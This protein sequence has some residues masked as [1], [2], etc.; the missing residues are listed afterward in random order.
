MKKRVSWR[1][2]RIIAAAVF[3]AVAVA[4][5]T[6]LAGMGAM[7]LH[8]Q[9]GPALL[10]LIAAFSAG[11]LAA[12]LG[13][14]LVTYL[15]GRFYCAVF[16]PLGI[17]QDV[18]GFLSRRKAVETRNFAWLRYAVAGVVFGMLAFGWTAGFFLLDPYSGFGRIVAS[19]SL[20]SL[21]PLAVITILAVWKKRIYC[22]AFCPVGTLLGLIAKHGVF[23][24]RITGKCVRCGK[25]VAQ[26]PSGC[27]DLDTGTIDNE[28]C[29]RCMNC[30]SRCPLHGIHL[31][32][33][34]RGSVPVDASR[35]A[36]LVGG[37]ALIAGFAAGAVLAK[38]GMRKFAEFAGRFRI[39]PPGAGSAVR[40]ASKCTGCQLC[41]ANCPTGAIRPLTL[42]EKQRTRI[43]E[44][45]FIPQNC[46]VFQ[47]GEQCGK[48]AGV[49]PVKAIT[50]RRTGAP[51]V[52]P[53]LCI[54]CGACREVCPAPEKALEIR[55]I[56]EQTLL[57]S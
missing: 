28:R 1:V 22:T 14:V 48:C 10:K 39:L 16:C 13:I 53:S 54:G 4:S 52:M 45:H 29:V 47:D 44:V 46:I 9:F 20:G 25:C 31:V 7:L 18:I 55:E 21:V 50:L 37:G 23:Q 5:F 41:T 38:V 36:F 32:R 27:I 3:L 12:V 26:C 49:C 51:R 56:A 6:G 17:L 8:V 42:N 15:F 33:P 19:F 34:E 2:V 40:F 24:L 11:T 35:R 30:L 57:R 43:A